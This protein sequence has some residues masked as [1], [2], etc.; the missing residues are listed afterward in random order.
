MFFVCRDFGAATFLQQSPGQPLCPGGEP[1][2]PVLPSPRPPILRL[3]HLPGAA[4]KWLQRRPAAVSMTTAGPP[5]TVSSPCLT[6]VCVCVCVCMF[7]LQRARH[8]VYH[9]A[10]Q[11][12]NQP[13]V[14]A[15]SVCFCELLGVCSLQL[16]VDVRALNAILQHRNTHAAE[17]QHAHTLG[18]HATHTHALTQYTH[19]TACQSAH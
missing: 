17:G 2:L 1:G 7:R 19:S 8:Q 13:P 18:R 11:C 3:R 6:R 9:L 14:A 15:A 5:T 12:F 10:L 16:R 4:A